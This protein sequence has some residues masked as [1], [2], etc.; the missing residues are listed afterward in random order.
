MAE[1]TVVRTIER[2]PDAVWGV[3]AAFDE[4]AWIPVDGVTV[5]GDGIGT[6]RFLPNADGPPI[7][8]QLDA[9]DHD[10]RVLRYSIENNPIPTSE[11]R[12][13]CSVR[14]DGGGATLE[15][16]VTFETSADE[17]EVAAMIDGAYSMLAGW[18][19]DATAG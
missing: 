15:W 9:I 12:V 2:D 11:Y 18:L 17:T 16:T 10:A 7:I 5:E 1:T 3:L 6:R 4:V 8:E 14:P 19:A 13:V